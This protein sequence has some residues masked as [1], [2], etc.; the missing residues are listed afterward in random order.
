VYL[1]GIEREF[2]AGLTDHEL[3]SVASALRKVVERPARW[4]PGQHVH[5]DDA[6][7]DDRIARPHDPAHERPEA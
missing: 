2:A 3:D 4:T 7:I 5:H 6:M 1:A